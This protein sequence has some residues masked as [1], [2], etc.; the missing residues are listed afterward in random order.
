M[1][2]T[3]GFSKEIGK[4]G[5]GEVQN[6]KSS[7]ILTASAFEDDLVAGRFAKWDTNSLDNMDKSATPNVAGVVVR[8]P[9]LTVESGGKYKKDLFEHVNYV[10]EGLVTVEAKSGESPKKFQKIYAYNG[11]SNS[12]ADL[13]KATVAT[14]DAVETN[15]E[16]IDLGRDDTVW[17][18]RLK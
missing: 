18:I 5:A 14:T 8:S 17:L 7:T 12:D 13:G 4:V 16:F 2:F 6:I 3:S 9:T 10:R 11:A 1:A 15:A